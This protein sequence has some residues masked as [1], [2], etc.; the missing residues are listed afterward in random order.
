MFGLEDV[1]DEP[2]P[3]PPGRWAQAAV[4]EGHICAIDLDGA[5]W[6]WGAN[7]SGQLGL[8]VPGDV[9]EPARVGTS[10]WR[11]VSTAIATTCGVQTDSSLWCWGA[12]PLG[13]V[14]N[15]DT[16]VMS[17]LEPTQIAGTWSHVSSGRNHT[18]AI[19]TNG[20]ASCWGSGTN[21][22]LG[23]GMFM[24]SLVPVP[25]MTSEGWTAIDVTDSATCALDKEQRAW[26]WGRGQFGELG[27]GTLVGRNTPGLVGPRRWQTL[28][29]GRLHSCAL[30]ED[31]VVACWGYNSSGQLGDPAVSY[32]VE[33][34]NPVLD[35]DPSFV[36]V[37]VGAD[38]SCA[39]KDDGTMWCWGSNT[40][41][42]SGSTGSTAFG[43]APQQVRLEP[44]D[45][46]EIAAG[47]R[48]SC[49]ITADHNLWCW[50][51]EIGE[52]RGQTIT[53]PTQVDGTW[54]HVA[55]GGYTTCAL[56]ADDAL[57][58][59][60][61][62]NRGQIGDGSRINRYAPKAVLG[63]P[64]RS[65]GV[66]ASQT[67][68]VDA[69]N[70]VWCWGYNAGGLGDGSTSRVEPTFIA[71]GYSSVSVGGV[72]LGITTTNS[73]MCWGGT[74]YYSY[75]CAG[76]G[77]PAP[78]PTAIG[79]ASWTSVSSGTQH[80]CGTTSTGLQCWGSG[81]YGQLGDNTYSDHYMPAPI[82]ATAGLETG[83]ASTG[84]N[85]TCAI[86]GTSLWCWG[87]NVSGELGG[88]P[89]VNGYQP[90]PSQVPGTWRA[91]TA[92]VQHA[93]AIATDGTLWCWGSNQRGQLGNGDIMPATAPRTQVGTETTWT[94]VAAADYH[95]CALREDGALF[96]WGMNLYG[97]LGIGGG[98]MGGLPRLVE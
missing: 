29:S 78:M 84:L 31:G 43:A 39:A 48:T 98:P 24:S 35:A 56:G 12:N 97:Q 25:V 46:T 6:C 3:P 68:A 33:N 94:A 71:S 41:S 65:F 61:S 21:G 67:C 85:F 4:G 93:C 17:V 37:G 50:G 69:A 14:G 95:T 87:T 8:G 64:W 30:R 9:V 28:Q 70:S 26:C 80:A 88:A 92:G 62:N 77:V 7:T 75:A 91:V 83:T 47:M 81:Y 55:A 66:G 36:A 11:M 63:G 73:L 44:Q 79:T 45:W 72:V 32:A 42:Q 18:C 40:D 54:K 38:H 10:T 13:Q 96:C 51:A 53:T 58:C 89:S 74:Y 52:I 34:P 59:W 5:L 49:G 57:A 2:P 60:G 86:N 82:V 23:H 22:E 90:A 27:N 76:V 19:D 1:P 15:G 16:S 20:A